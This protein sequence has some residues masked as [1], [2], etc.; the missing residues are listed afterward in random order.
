M[1]RLIDRILK[2]CETFRASLVDPVEWAQITKANLQEYSEGSVQDKKITN[3]LPAITAQIKQA[4]PVA[5]EEFDFNKLE[6]VPVFAADDVGLYTSPLPKGTNMSG[7]VASMAPTF[8]RFFMKISQNT[9][10]C[11]R[12]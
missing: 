7:V 6:G 9:P 1:S 11:A 3:Q 12:G 5:I 10:C 8:D 2:G 4:E